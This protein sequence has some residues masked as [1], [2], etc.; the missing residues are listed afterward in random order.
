MPDWER[1]C[2]RHCSLLPQVEQI[3]QAR[4][5]WFSSQ[6]ATFVSGTA[7][8]IS[9]VPCWGY[10]R[11]FAAISSSMLEPRAQRRSRTRGSVLLLTDTSVV[12]GA[13]TSGV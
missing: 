4:S 6:A 5:T 11:R 10:S 8:M 3:S 2:G 7:R 9:E 13:A 12:I 1:I